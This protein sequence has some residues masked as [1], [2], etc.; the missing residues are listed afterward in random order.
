VRSIDDVTYADRPDLRAVLLA[1]YDSN[2]W[3]EI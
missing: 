2:P 3:D 1:A